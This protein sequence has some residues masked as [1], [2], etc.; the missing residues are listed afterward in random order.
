MAAH[1]GVRS[2]V[3]IDREGRAGQRYLTAYVVPNPACDLVISELRTFLEARLPDAM[4]PAFFIPLA[5]L[6]LTSNG[7]VDRSSL[8]APDQSRSES[9]KSLLPARDDWELR[10]TQIWEE[11]LEI[12]PIGVK[13]NFFQLGGHSLLAVRLRFQLH[14]M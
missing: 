2:V 4:V 7:K 14:K 3:V 12:Y 9:Q 5:A 8:P 1:P 6:P 11:I 10:L 13:D